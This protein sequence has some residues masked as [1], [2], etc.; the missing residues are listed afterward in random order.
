MFR[1]GVWGVQVLRGASVREYFGRRAFGSNH[2]MVIAHMTFGGMIGPPLV[3]WIF[4]ARTSYSLA[5]LVLLV[6]NLIAVPVVLGV[7]KHQ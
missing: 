2:G 4:D 5:W 6:T 7:I 3:G 1:A